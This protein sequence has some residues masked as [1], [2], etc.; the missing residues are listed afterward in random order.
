MPTVRDEV[1]SS[2]PVKILLFTHILGLW[3]RTRLAARG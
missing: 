1:Q 3:T 2:P